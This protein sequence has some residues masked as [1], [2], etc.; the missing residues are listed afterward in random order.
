MKDSI[1]AKYARCA[2]GQNLLPEATPELQ[3]I[4]RESLERGWLRNDYRLSRMFA[5]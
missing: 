2:R 3:M 5:S 1:P 4:L